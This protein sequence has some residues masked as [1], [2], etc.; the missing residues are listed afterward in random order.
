MTIV[1]NQ[2]VVGWLR[3]AVTNT[4]QFQDPSLRGKADI[5]NSL[6]IGTAIANR[7]ANISQNQTFG[8]GNLSAKA[9]IARIRAATKAKF[10]EADKLA[11]QFKIP[12]KKVDK[13]VDKKV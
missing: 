3:Q 8:M 12:I 1:S 13:K 6:D 5:Q 7:F 4:A 2:Y 10:A 9:A 11:A